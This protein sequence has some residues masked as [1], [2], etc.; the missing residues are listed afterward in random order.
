MA[1]ELIAFYQLGYGVAAFGVGPL[2]GGTGMAFST[3]FGGA[4]IVAAVLAG[5]TFFV[6]RRPSPRFSASN[7]P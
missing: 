3:L 6:I 1:G 4:S 2:R 5:I 7:L